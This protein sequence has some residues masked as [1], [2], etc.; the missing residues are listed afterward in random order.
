MLAQCS[1]VVI[2][3]PFYGEYVL[4]SFKLVSLLSNMYHKT[5]S[6]GQL[7]KSLEERAMQLL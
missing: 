4:F 6:G 1:A 2:S 7:S 3:H 5:A